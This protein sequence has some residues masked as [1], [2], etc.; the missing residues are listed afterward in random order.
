MN[1]TESILGALVISFTSLAIGKYYGSNG[2]VKDNQCL[3][4]R[5][6]CFKLLS[7]RI[8]NLI[9]KVEDLAEMVNKKFI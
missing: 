7:E 6:S 4:R 3:E 8:D 9:K 1:P 2:K 5:D